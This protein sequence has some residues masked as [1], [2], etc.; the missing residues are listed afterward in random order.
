M[1]HTEASM[2]WG[3]RYAPHVGYLPP[4]VELL[5]RALAGA[6]RAAHVEFAAREGFAGILYPWAAESAAA[7]RV[8]VRQALRATGL[9]CSCVVSAPMSAILD[10][11]WVTAGAA[12]D[13]RALGYVRHALAVA[14]EL[15]SGILAVLIRGDGT[16][17]TTTQWQRAADR[18]RA[19]A[20]LAARQGVVL[21]VE[22]MIDLPEMLLPTFA[23]A[24]DFVH[25]VAHPGVKL[26]FDT[27][28]VTRM[29]DPLQSSFV[30]AYDDIAL[31]QL[32]DMPGRIEPGAG[33]IEFVPL[34]A[35]AMRRGYSGLVDLEHGWSQ[36][37]QDAE[38]HGL[39][40]LRRL[41]Q[42]AQ[43]VLRA[44]QRASRPDRKGR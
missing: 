14:Q 29:G 27:G 28:H 6:D 11:L 22:P 23:T 9:D 35:H 44:D 13:E 3:L 39:Q 34:L 15:G 16:Q 20:D 2:G 40:L 42:S 37:G 36:P 1:A 33:S 26:I 17:S 12:A 43:E 41:D 30:D 21:A 19:S 31:L 32:A 10:P 38:R 8:S 5:F 4:D 7:Q 24:V 18:L 25:H